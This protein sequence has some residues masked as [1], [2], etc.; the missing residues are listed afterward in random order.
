M[1]SKGKIIQAERMD[2][3]GQLNSNVGLKVTAEMMP[4]FRVV[5]FYRI[6]WHRREE[7]V[8]D[9]VWVDVAN[10]CPGAVS[11]TAE[12]LTGEGGRSSSKEK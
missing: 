2:V 4:S 3:S 5:A 1:L 10:T 8:A 6:P 9:S 7:V 11:D 12:R